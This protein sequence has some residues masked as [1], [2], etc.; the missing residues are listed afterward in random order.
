M[1]VLTKQTERRKAF[2][3]K[4]F[5]FWIDNRHFGQIRFSKVAISLKY[6]EESKINF[7]Q[8]KDISDGQYLG[9]CFRKYIFIVGIRMCSAE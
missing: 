3:Q 7:L 5:I 2:L 9:K 8:R 4:P 1:N 6:T